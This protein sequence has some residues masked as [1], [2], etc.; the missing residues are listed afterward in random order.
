MNDMFN[1]NFRSVMNAYSDLVGKK[2]KL[3]IPFSLSIYIVVIPMLLCIAYTVYVVTGSLYPL[4]LGFTI[5]FIWTLIYAGRYYGFFSLYCIFLYTSIFFIY[6]VVFAEVLFP[7]LNFDFL[8]IRWPKRIVFD[9][10]IGFKF[11]VASFI[12]IYILHVFYCIRISKHKKKSRI[13]RK[14]ILLLIQIGEIMMGIFFFPALV[15][16]YLQVKYVIQHGYIS[17][18]T[19]GFS[20]INYPFWV[21]GAYLG[22]MAGYCLFLAGNPSKEQFKRISLLYIAFSLLNSLKGQRGNVISLIII[23]IYWYRKK[24][25]VT[26]KIRKYIL[27]GLVSIVLIVSLDTIRVEYGGNNVNTSNNISAVV[28]TLIEQSRSRVVPMLVMKG[29][30]QYRHYPFVFSPLLTPYYAFKYGYGQT[31]KIAR[32]TNDI[33]NVTMYNISRPAYLNGNGFGGSFLAEAYDLGGYIGVAFLSFLLAQILA[34]CDGSNLDVRNK[35]IPLLF[36]FLINLPML[37]RNRF[38]GFMNSYL[39][40]GLTYFVLLIV[41]LIPRKHRAYEMIINK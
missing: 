26:I 16:T 9:I 32:N 35:Y 18:F 23:C 12:E 14:S 13:E 3:Y 28:D 37:P 36:Q 39:A 29:D 17:I 21:S 41:L 25:D 2:G 6:S 22:L 15:K 7:F 8:T 34:I 10:D 30:L 31:D 33:S 5:T 27:V 24:Y 40:I 19:N 20:K 4:L 11:I 38:F 1:K